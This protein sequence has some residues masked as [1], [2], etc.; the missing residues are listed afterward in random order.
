MHVDTDAVSKTVKGRVAGAGAERQRA[1]PSQLLVKRH[2]SLVGLSGTL[3]YARPTQICVPSR[4]GS[5]AL[6]APSVLV[7]RTQ[8]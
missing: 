1:L 3:W 2:S 5:V 4:L 6:H 7:A 8:W